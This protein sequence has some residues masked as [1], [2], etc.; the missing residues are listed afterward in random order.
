MKTLKQKILVYAVENWHEESPG[1]SGLAI[2]NS[3]KVKHDKVLKIFDKLEREKK[4]LVIRDI[5]LSE[6]H[7][8][9]NG[10]K[11]EDTKP[12]KT[13]IFFPAKEVL[14][15]SFYSSNLHRLNIPEYKSSPV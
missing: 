10:S 4:G 12:I 8:S 6:F 9:I 2:S 3:L 11:N 13:S 1:I 14:S 5:P 7:I 15:D